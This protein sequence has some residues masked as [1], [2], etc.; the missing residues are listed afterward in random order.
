MTA[1]LYWM[2]RIPTILVLRAVLQNG[3]RLADQWMPACDFRRDR[4]AE[5]PRR[6][7]IGNVPGG[8]LDGN[9]PV[10]LRVRQ[11]HLQC[12]PVFR[13][14]VPETCT[15][16]GML[17]RRHNRESRSLVT[18]NERATSRFGSTHSRSYSSRLEMVVSVAFGARST[19]STHPSTSPS[20][21]R[22]GVVFGVVIGVALLAALRQGY[23]SSSPFVIS[24][25]R[26]RGTMIQRK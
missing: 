10:L 9:L 16:I 13:P 2:L 8:W 14:P 15:G 25:A 1:S 22:F 23:F 24:S 20:L 18:P 26:S 5:G 4:D 3:S 21:N 6:P 11:R 7:A 19:I 12:S 17:F